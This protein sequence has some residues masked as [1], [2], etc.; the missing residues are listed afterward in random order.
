MTWKKNIGSTIRHCHHTNFFKVKEGHNINMWFF[1][2]YFKNNV[3]SQMKPRFVYKKDFL[4]QAVTKMCSKITDNSQSSLENRLHVIVSHL[5]L[6]KETVLNHLAI[7]LGK[8][9]TIIPIAALNIAWMLYIQH[10]LEFSYISS[11][12]GNS[13]QNSSQAA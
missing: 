1:N 4:Q 3:D 8:L 5:L 13:S 6:D 12:L 11:L 2:A 7:L 10:F 9:H